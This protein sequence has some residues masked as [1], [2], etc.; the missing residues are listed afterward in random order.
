MPSLNE[1]ARLLSEGT[2]TQ[3]R[4]SWR[5]LT[6]EG[7]LWGAC[8][9]SLHPANAL[10]YLERA[11]E[12]LAREWDHS[13]LLD[14]CD[15]VDL[16]EQVRSILRLVAAAAVTAACE[17]ADPERAAGWALRAAGGDPSRLL[18]PRD[19]WR[20][21]PAE[22]RIRACFRELRG[23]YPELAQAVAA[24]QDASLGL[25]WS[26]V[27]EEKRPSGPRVRMPVLL[28]RG[29]DGYLSWLWLERVP[30]GSGQLFQAP[31]TALGGVLPELRRSIEAACA[32]GWPALPPGEDVR[33]WLTDLPRGADH[34]PI[35][36]GGCSAGAAA[37]VALSHLLRRREVRAHCAITA[38]L[39]PDGRLGEV[40]GLEGSAPKLQAARSLAGARNPAT[41]IVGPGSQLSA[42]A[43]AAWE[44]Q[45]VRVVV[46]HTLADAERLSGEE[47]PV[48]RD[49]ASRAPGRPSAA[50]TPLSVAVLYAYGAAEDR[51]LCRRVESRLQEQGLDVRIAAEGTFGVAWARKADQRLRGADLVIAL[52]TPAARS[53]EMLTYELQLAEEAAQEGG[54]PRRLFLRVDP[55]ISPEQFSRA[56]ASIPV[57]DWSPED[58]EALTPTGLQEAIHR[59]STLAADE[60]AQLLPPTGVLPLDSRFYLEREADAQFELA[61]ARGDSIIRIK[62]A[63]QMGKTSLLARG[64]QQARER[65]ATI[66]LT[67]FQLLNQEHL[68]EVDGFFR[69]L[70]RWLARQAGTGLEVDAVW[71]PLQGA[72]VNFRDFL[73]ELLEGLPGPVVWGLDEVDRLFQCRFHTEVFGMLR[74]LHNDRALNPSLPW[75]RLTLTLCYA[76][77]AQL[78]L[79]D[80]NQ[81]PF[82]VGTR[83]RLDDFS[84]E[85]V[86]ELND[87]Y[88]APLRSPAELADYYELLAGHPYLTHLGLHQLVT[89]GL[90]LAGL[91]R[92]AH[93]EDALFGDHLRRMLRLLSREEELLHAVR[94]LLSGRPCPAGEEFYRLWSAGVVVGDSAYDARLRCGLYAAYLERH[95]R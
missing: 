50:Q 80:L 35:P 23:G 32:T 20:L 28:A 12:H 2:R 18:L 26:V 34:L 82:N 24:A 47:P 13:C 91:K 17:E 19:E 64:L 81:S 70:A 89:R 56:A 67:D 90:S 36:V 87:R 78:F 37:A 72:S 40:E 33:W 54:R 46:A 41:V 31:S 62:G 51:D 71:D 79:A 77:E 10:S 53:S 5:V 11:Y 45:H 8:R 15:S 93:Q 58:P 60:R 55:S 75:S 94:E 76:T 83:I 16:R 59:S 7:G 29:S 9:S 44:A 86:G 43:A 65:A 38:T 49:P 1:L 21:L 52:L 66:L 25:L 57:L 42:V 14:E 3:K 73:L 69:F 85:E 30:G 95:L 27:G 63:R 61:I 74:S 39:L 88:G 22:G 6:A 68:E 92:L 4:R 84:Y 48:R